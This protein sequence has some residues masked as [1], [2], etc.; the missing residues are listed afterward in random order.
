MG[1]NCKDAGK[2]HEMGVED[3]WEDAGI[4]GER[5]RENGKDEDKIR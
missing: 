3:R 4:Y 5:R 2:I 1:K